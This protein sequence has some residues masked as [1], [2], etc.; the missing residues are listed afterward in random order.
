EA[1]GGKE[2]SGTFIVPSDD[3]TYL[4]H[5]GVPQ[6]TE[7]GLK[8]QLVVGRG[9]KDLPSIPG[10]TPPNYTGSLDRAR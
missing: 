2:V 10:I 6:H 8:A 4:V 3:A 1:N 9:G 5:C 7:K